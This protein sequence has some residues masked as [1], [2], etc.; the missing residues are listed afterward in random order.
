MSDVHT[1]PTPIS[2]PPRSRRRRRAIVAVILL[3]IVCVGCWAYRQFTTPEIPEPFDV[4]GHVAY[5]LPDE[6]NAF[7][8]YRRAVA[9]LVKEDAVFAANPSFKRDEFWESWHATAE[10]GWD[11]AVPSVRQWVKLNGP[12]LAELKRGAGCAESLEFPLADAANEDFLSF[13]WGTLQTCIRVQTL[14]G[15]RLTAERHPEEAWS[16]FR[17]SLRTSRHLAMH[18]S[19][20]QTMFGVVFGEQAAQAAVIWAAEPSVGPADLRRAIHDL[21]TVE[22][23]RAPASDQLKL[24]YLWLRANA[25]RGT[26]GLSPTPSWVRA[27]GYP[28]Q[29]GQNARLVV[30][31]LITQADRPK[32]ERTA[33]HPGELHLYELD[34][35]T[36]H[37]PR[38]RPPAE[39]EAA[40]TNS[41]AALAKVL[42]RISPDSAQQLAYCDPSL[43]LGG[44]WQASQ[45][46]DIAQAHRS[47][48]LLALALELYYRE[49][50]EFPAALN[51]LVARG[52]LP[53]IPLDPLGTG[54]SY[55]YRREAP[56]TRGATLWSVYTDG[57]DNGGVS[58][59][60]GKG[61]L[62]LR[63]PAPG[64][65]NQSQ[66]E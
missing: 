51:E 56:A 63:V 21:G 58:L 20:I 42:R 15:L 45:H 9:A 28:A 62:V 18:A 46:R 12:M 38:L 25:T 40:A 1:L 16:C 8:Y 44:L 61:D 30:A 24:E 22:A 39:I 65:D 2:S 33:I 32:Y 36:P 50:H 53:S 13:E 49:H 3:A 66:P 41:A 52:I 31:N 4:A 27:T 5:T 10:K 6:K 26:L 59:H 19:P 37:D 14:E 35:A 60:D 48:L 23:M 43:L 34:P 57:I 47:A 64:A 29:I 11:Y 54:E 55:H 17:D 7:A